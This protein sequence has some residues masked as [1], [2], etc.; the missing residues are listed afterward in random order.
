MFPSPSDN[1]LS[2]SCVADGTMDRLIFLDD[3]T[4]GITPRLLRGKWAYFT[5]DG[6]RIRE[7]AEI[8]R[9]NQV[10][11]P[12]GTRRTRMR[13]CWRSD[14]NARGRKQYRYHPDNRTTAPPPCATDTCGSRAGYCVCAFAESRDGC[15]T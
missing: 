11:L 13:I 4:P 3:T 6:K 9:L 15:A 5:P 10:A 7:E 2:G 1:P 14:S 8:A 12:P